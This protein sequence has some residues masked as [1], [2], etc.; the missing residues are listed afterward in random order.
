MNWL[1]EIGS[2]I[3]GALDYAWYVAERW[4]EITNNPKMSGSTL[5]WIFWLWIVMLPFAVPVL[6]HNLWHRNLSWPVVVVVGLGLFFVPDLFCRFR[7]T[8]QRRE[9][10]GWKYRH[11]R[12][13]GS[14]LAWLFLLGIVLTIAAFRLSFLLGLLKFDGND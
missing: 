9:A 13:I 10:L 12:N 5:F 1:N 3:E 4:G 14:R 8:E 6:H 2:K 7:Y 11:I